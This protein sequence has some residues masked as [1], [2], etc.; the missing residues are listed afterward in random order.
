MKKKIIIFLCLVCL[1]LSGCRK[2]QLLSE[3]LLTDYLEEEL[4]YPLVVRSLEDADIPCRNAHRDGYLEFPFRST[5]GT[6]IETDYERPY[7]AIAVRN[8]SHGG[9]TVTVEGSSVTVPAGDACWIYTAQK[10]PPGEHVLSFSAESGGAIK[11]FMELWLSDSPETMIPSYRMNA[12]VLSVH[13]DYFQAQP[14]PE[15]GRQN[16][17]EVFYVSIRE[18]NGAEDTLQQGDLVEIT[19]TGAFT[20]AEPY[21]LKDITEL[22]ILE[23]EGIN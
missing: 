12:R 23:T 7:W 21:I 3:F 10:V 8:Q 17:P 19:Y 5:A 13:D 14:F 4:S 6:S 9:L 22:R 11:G 18:R 16:L 20:P 1:L 15:E 2:P